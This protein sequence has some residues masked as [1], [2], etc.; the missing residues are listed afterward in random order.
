MRQDDVLRSFASERVQAEELRIVAAYARRQPGQRYS[1]FQPAHTFCAQVIERRMLE[2]LKV[3]GVATLETARVLEVGCGTGHWL[4][5]FVEWGAQPANVAGLDLLP[6]RVEEARRLC[7]SGVALACGSATALPWPDA[8]FDIVMQSTVFTSIRDARVRE[9]VAAEMLRVVKNEGL[10]IWY[11]YHR[12]NPWNADVRGVK[13]REIRRLFQGCRLRVR[14]M[15]LAPPIARALA[16]YS[17]LACELLERLPLL[18]TH[19]L[20]MISRR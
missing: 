11:D 18:C 12:D 1:W 15:T 10:I 9:L 19:Y 7:P 5:Q 13:M 3:S 17:W 2:A 4:R 14:R 6:E 8:T 20:V 16:P